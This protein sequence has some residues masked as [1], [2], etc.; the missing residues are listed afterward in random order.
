MD[1]MGSSVVVSLSVMALV[2]AAVFGLRKFLTTNDSQR[3]QLGLV[4]AIIV[5]ICCTTLLDDHHNYVMKW[6]V[7][8]I[9]LLRQTTMLSLIALGAAVVIIAGGIDLSAGSVM[10]FSASIC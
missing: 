2:A 4:I 6:Q 1:V 5:V 8:V 7:S 3:H 9:D 10:A